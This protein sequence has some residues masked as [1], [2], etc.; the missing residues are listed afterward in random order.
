MFPFEMK[1]EFL[2]L[3]KLLFSAALVIPVSTAAM[4]KYSD[5]ASESPSSIEDLRKLCKS[6]EANEQIKMFTMIIA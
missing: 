2:M 5:S 3:K 6:L 4:A 1:K